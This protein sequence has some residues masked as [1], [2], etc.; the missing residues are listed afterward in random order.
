MR[1]KI[2][3]M[4][5]IGYALTILYAVSLV[6]YINFY[7]VDEI[8]LIVLAVLFG[9]LLTGSIGI[10][11]LKE[12]GRNLIV[13]TSAMMALY[14]FITH[15]VLDSAIPIAYILMNVIILLFFSQAKIRDRFR[16]VVNEWRSILVVD[17]D[18]ILVKTVRHIL[19]SHG[20]SVLAANTGESGLQ[21]AASQKPDLILL[22]VLLPGI[23][24]REVCKKI[25]E[26]EA[27]K[28][29]PIVFLTAKDSSD[30][31]KAEMEAGG[32]THIT[33]PVHA[34]TLLLMVKEIL[35]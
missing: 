8:Q 35:G 14:L 34:K 23:K 3:V 26:D 12:W 28:H 17:D 31:I 24:G 11:Q 6:L 27:T 21:I 33:K 7:Q 9:L 22:D 10:S 18:E 20:Y 30:D 4:K 32:E 29:I 13:F 5:I 16:S 25:K 19:M 15:L 1:K 2:L